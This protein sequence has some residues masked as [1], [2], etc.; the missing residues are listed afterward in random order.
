MMFLILT[1]DLTNFN[2]S[3]SS[4]GI[5][6]YD[7]RNGAIQAHVYDVFDSLMTLGFAS[8]VPTYDSP[9]YTC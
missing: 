4:Y 9:S 6:S 3:A 8:S 7:I 1:V 5:R 2:R